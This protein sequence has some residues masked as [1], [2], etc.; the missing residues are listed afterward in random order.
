MVIFASKCAVVP[1]ELLFFPPWTL[2][3]M[4][5]RR[6]KA[7]KPFPRNDAPTL[8]LTFVSCRG[9]KKKKKKES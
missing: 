8:D 2:S 6:R 7:L 9:Q 1:G 5:E 4:N 3:C